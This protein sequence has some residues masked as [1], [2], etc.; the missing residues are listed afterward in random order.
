MKQDMFFGAVKTVFE[1]ARALRKNMTEAEKLL[2]FHLKKS[3]LGFKFRR[4]HPLDSFVAD[5]YCHKAKLVIELDGSIHNLEDIK[6]YDGYR[7]RIIEE[8]GLTVLRFTNK[9]TFSNPKEILEIIC[10]HLEK[11]CLPP[12]SP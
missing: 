4:Q 10:E 5:F 2:W 11:F 8:F 3:P 9:Q 7:Q 6:E 12:K 1:N